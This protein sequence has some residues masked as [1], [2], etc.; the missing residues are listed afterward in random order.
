[1]RRME[2]IPDNEEEKRENL[3]SIKKRIM[4]IYSSVEEAMTSTFYTCYICGGHN[5]E[6]IDYV[7]KQDG[8]IKDF[9]LQ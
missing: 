6:C 8:E 9:L 4:K 5:K 2:K 1:M 7:C 3:C